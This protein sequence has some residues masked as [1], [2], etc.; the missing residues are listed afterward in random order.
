M[1]KRSGSGVNITNHISESLETIFWPKILKLFVADAD[2]D[3]VSGNLFDPGSG[4]EKI[5]IRDKHPLICNTATA[6]PLHR[7]DRNKHIR[8]LQGPG[9]CVQQMAQ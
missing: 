9:L 3:P 5:R 6:I 4:M 2:P 8:Y 1:G 7:F